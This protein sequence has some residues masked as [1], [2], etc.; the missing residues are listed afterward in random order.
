MTNFEAIKQNC[1]TIE[2]LAEW[3]SSVTEQGE[4]PWNVWFDENYCSKCAPEKAKSNFTGLLM[5]FC[6]C[7]LHNHRCKYFENWEEV[8]YGKDLIKLWLGEYSIERSV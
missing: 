5:D 3:L 2:K 8:P 4:E 6:W 7:E 1:D